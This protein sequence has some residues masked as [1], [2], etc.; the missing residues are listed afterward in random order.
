MVVISA[1][2]I[3]CSNSSSGPAPE[4]AMNLSQQTRITGEYLVTLAP[5]TDPKGI[6]EQYGRFQIKRIQSL[7]RDVYLVTLGEDPGPEQMKELGAR[8]AHVKA[9]QPNRASP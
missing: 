2:E 4:P 3:A 5:G 1:A 8:S 9:V 7:G 6:D